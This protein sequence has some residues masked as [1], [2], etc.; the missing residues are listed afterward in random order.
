ML[1]KSNIVANL[2]SEFVPKRQL[3]RLDMLVLSDFLTV[4]IKWSNTIQRV[5]DL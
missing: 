5:K 2:K 4:H 1:R 3:C